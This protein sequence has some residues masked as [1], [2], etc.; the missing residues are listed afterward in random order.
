MRHTARRTGISPLHFHFVFWILPTF[1]SA[2]L[3][4]AYFSGLEPLR[5]IVAPS[6]NRELGVLEH[7][8]TFLLLVTTVGG[9]IGFR[10]AGHRVEKAVSALLAVGSAV[11]LLEEVDFGL[12]YW[13]LVFGETGITNL[14]LHNQGEALPVI[15][16]A[17]DALTIILFVVIP[18]AAWR[19]SDPRLRY[20]LPHPLTA[21]TVLGGF[22]VS[23]LAHALDDAGLYPGGPLAGNISEFRE[24]FT[25]YAIMIYGLDLALLRRWP[26]SVPVPAVDAVT[27]AKDGVLPPERGDAIRATR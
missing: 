1:G 8:Q 4:L 22:C 23:L 11:L 14:N 21:M 16:R 15:K 13:E 25:Y 5:S 9:I 2:A 3:A 12:H 10:Q 6:P 7:L 19:V 24:T 18:L 20:F 17:S 27:A 26:S